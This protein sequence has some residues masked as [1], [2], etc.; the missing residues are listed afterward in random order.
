[1]LSEK[2]GLKVV[3]R[4]RR[5]AFISILTFYLTRNVLINPSLAISELLRIESALLTFETE[6]AAQEF[7]WNMSDNMWAE[8][9]G[10][11]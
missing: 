9:H 6:N 3:P 5:A 4:P 2:Q 10:D 1:M 7:L 11:P 8:R